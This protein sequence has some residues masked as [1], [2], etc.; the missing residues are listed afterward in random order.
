MG[1]VFVQMLPCVGRGERER[2]REREDENIYL[3]LSIQMFGG[4]YSGTSS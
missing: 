2:E 1:K 3:N 4:V